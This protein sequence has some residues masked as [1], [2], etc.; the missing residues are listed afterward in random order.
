MKDSGLAQ[1]CQSALFLWQ[2]K[3]NADKLCRDAI[4]D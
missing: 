4:K 3:E 1:L 2:R